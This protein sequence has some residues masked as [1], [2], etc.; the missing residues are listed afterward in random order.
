MRM[1]RSARVALVKR[2]MR[3]K[4]TGRRPVRVVRPLMVMKRGKMKTRSIRGL[5][6]MER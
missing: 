1:R 3:R 6:K 2:R 5:Q 4:M